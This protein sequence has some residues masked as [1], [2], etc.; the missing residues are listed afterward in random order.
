MHTTRQIHIEVIE[1]ELMKILNVL[2]IV[3]D[4]PN[5]VD[6]FKKNLL[7]NFIRISNITE[8][9][10]KPFKIDNSF[11]STEITA[12]FYSVRG[13]TVAKKIYI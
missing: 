4:K 13:H 7:L 1:N 12:G 9:T 3:H 11:N 2:D 5:N 10:E 6:F 8:H